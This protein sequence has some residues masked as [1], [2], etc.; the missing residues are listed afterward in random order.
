MELHF[1]WICTELDK[2][3]SIAKIAISIEE[4]LIEKLSQKT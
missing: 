2:S 4:I 1:Q 3:I